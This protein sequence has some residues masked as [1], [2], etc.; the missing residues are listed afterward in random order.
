MSS[1][2]LLVY[3]HAVTFFALL[4][5]DT[6]S[7]Q[8]PPAPPPPP[9][10]CDGEH[11]AAPLFM[12]EPAEVSQRKRVVILLRGRPFYDHFGHDNPCPSQSTPDGKDAIALQLEATKSVIEKVVKPLEQR[13]NTVEV[14]FTFKQCDQRLHTELSSTLKEM[15]NDDDPL[16][17]NP[18]QDLY[19]LY[20]DR[21]VLLDAF[22]SV[23]QN[24]N[25]RMALLSLKK[26]AGGEA[27]AVSAMWDLILIIRHDTIFKKSLE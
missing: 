10:A 19:E 7:G 26:A 9:L 12:P 4:C 27:D 11:C 2:A 14:V 25:M 13:Q 3:H 8:I 24:D 15:S 20:G 21:I 16:G 1:P 18:I 5:L 17:G 6:S 22:D 23:N